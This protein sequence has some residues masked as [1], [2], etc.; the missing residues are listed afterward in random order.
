MTA[1]SARTANTGDLDGQPEATVIWQR[2]GASFLALL[3]WDPA[4]R[5]VTMPVHDPVLGVGICAVK[6]CGKPVASSGLCV[7]CRVRLTASGQTRD[8]FVLAAKRRWR[9]I[10]AGRC[11]VPE[12]ERPWKSRNAGLCRAHDRHRAKLSGL[13]LEKFICH[14]RCPPAA[15]LR[16]MRGA[17]VLPRCRRAD[18]VLRPAPPPAAGRSPKPWL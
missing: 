10:G 15:R 1:A 4:H 5:V 6:D 7:G 9:A 18:G 14:P 12:C 16:A 11:T 13:S 2:V 3:G 17:R 8:E